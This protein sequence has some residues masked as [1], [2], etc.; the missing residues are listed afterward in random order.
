VGG[1]G[2]GGGGGGSLSSSER[3]QPTVLNINPVKLG[4]GPRRK[5]KSRPLGLAMKALW[6]DWGSFGAR[7]SNQVPER[8]KLLTGASTPRKTRSAYAENPRRSRK[9][10]KGGSAR[11]DGEKGKSPGVWDISG[12]G[13]GGKR[14]LKKGGKG[15][16]RQSVAKGGKG[17][18]RT[19]II[20]KGEKNVGRCSRKR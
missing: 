5:E 2:G 12:L 11:P 19:V 1:G 9:R 3:Q 18:A 4:S 7:K 13:F 6:R 16:G 17:A 8:R 14:Y 20:H 15:S 10:E